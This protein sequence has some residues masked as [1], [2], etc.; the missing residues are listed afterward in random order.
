M[1]WLN[2]WNSKFWNAIYVSALLFLIVD[3][4]RSLLIYKLHNWSEKT[5]YIFKGTEQLLFDVTDINVEMNSIIWWVT[6]H[7]K[8]NI[9]SSKRTIIKKGEE[10]MKSIYHGAFNKIAFLMIILIVGAY[11]TISKNL[12]KH[13]HEWGYLRGVEVG[14]KGT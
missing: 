2:N 5:F 12:R 13:F 4:M 11:S 7:W 8:H 1:N 9:F 6:M 14:N 10:T 3:T